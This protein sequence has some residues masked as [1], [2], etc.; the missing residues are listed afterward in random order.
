MVQS[1]QS[2]TDSIT[3]QETL[4]S[5]W[6]HYVLFLA[7]EF[8]LVFEISKMIFFSF[9]RIVLSVTRGHI[10]SIWLNHRWPRDLDFYMKFQS[11]FLLVSVQFDFRND[12][13]LDCI[14]AR[15]FLI[16]P[17]WSFC[18]KHGHFFTCF[19]RSSFYWKILKI[20]LASIAESRVAY[21]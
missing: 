19:P 9:I 8:W 3:R 12:V 16:V 13:W 1:C 20:F 6:I 17:T 15:F 21:H 7:K 5:S 2:G 4:W 14:V 11:C 10:R 18:G